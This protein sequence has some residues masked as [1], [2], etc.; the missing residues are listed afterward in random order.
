LQSLH[1]MKIIATPTLVAAFAAVLFAGVV[2]VPAARALSPEGEPAP[3]RGSFEPATLPLPE[4]PFAIPDAP[5]DAHE[6]TQMRS[7]WFTF[8]VG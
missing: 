1:A 8:K 6:H 5:H 7:R 4:K 2:C 3:A